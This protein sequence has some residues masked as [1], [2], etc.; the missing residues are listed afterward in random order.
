MESVALAP[1]TRVLDVNGGIAAHHGVDVIAL[2]SGTL[3][4]ALVADGDGVEHD[5]PLAEIAAATQFAVVR[6]AIAGLD[7]ALV[8]Q[9]QAA[10]T[11]AR[12]QALGANVARTVLDT[13]ARNQQSASQEVA[14][15]TAL[16]DQ[17]R[18]QLKNYTIRA[19]LTGTVLALFAE[20]GQSID[21]S[22]R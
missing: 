12:T 13:A 18:S 14:R 20:H 4:N 6:Q 8:A 15:T 21:P 7:A 10:D 1:A 17:T 5:K 19:P 2:V 11:Y 9:A 16:V 22:T 3:A